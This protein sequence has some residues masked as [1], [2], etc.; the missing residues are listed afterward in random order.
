MQKTDRIIIL[1]LII[2]IWGVIGTLW[3]RPNIV[4]AD[5]IKNTQNYAK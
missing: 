4:I 2:G 5:H 1:F 3:F